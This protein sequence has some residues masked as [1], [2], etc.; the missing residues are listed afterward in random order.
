MTKYFIKK[1][2]VAPS[3][4]FTN[5]GVYCESC[6]K[7]LDV[8]QTNM[9]PETLIVLCATCYRKYGHSIYGFDGTE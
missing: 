9:N 4:S 1:V 6:H 2:K 5:H 7:E 3:W 8:P